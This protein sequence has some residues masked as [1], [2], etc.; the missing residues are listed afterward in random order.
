MPKLSELEGVNV[1]T[2]GQI[3]FMFDVVIENAK[4]DPERIREQLVKLLGQ[5][6]AAVQ[7]LLPK[8]VKL[9]EFAIDFL[10]LYEEDDYDRYM[11]FDENL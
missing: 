5:Q 9:G 6:L 3:G 2:N 1:R 4:E 7:G 10:D 8:G 11:A